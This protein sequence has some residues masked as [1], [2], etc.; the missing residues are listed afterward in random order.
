MCDIPTTAVF[1]ENLLNTFLI[2]F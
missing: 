1:V 2:L